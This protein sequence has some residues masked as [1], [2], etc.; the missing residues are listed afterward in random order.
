LSNLTCLIYDIKKFAIHDG[1]GI[2]TT[3][4]FK[5]CPLSCHW[6][7]NPE[8]ILGKQSLIFNSDRCIGC[9]ECC[10][11][12]SN[13][14]LKQT[15]EGIEINRD[16]CDLCGACTE[17]CPAQAMELQGRR[18]SV[19]DLAALIKKDLIFYDSSQGGVTFS[20]GE[21]LAQ[22]EALVAL[23][24]ELKAEE[25]HTIVDTCGF[26]S[27]KILDTVAK[28]TNMFLY[29]L[30]V[31]DPEKHKYYTG[32]SNLG[33][34]SNLEKLSALGRDI[35]IRIPLIPG[36]N[37]SEKDLE[38]FGVFL[39]RLPTVSQVEILPYH[40]FH[41]SKYEKLNLDYRMKGI[42]VPSCAEVNDA[43]RI[44]QGYGLTVTAH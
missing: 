26:S 44:L 8:S 43:I 34:L 35:I 37:N 7:H 29:D 39:S 30:K 16:K 11:I 3:V 25:L 36:I 14:A 1:P 41:I 42:L 4:F 24:D 33:I 10:E 6:C 19:S 15:L 17:V 12:C 32:V 9:L 20:G 13:K 38:M 23:L 2:R 27:W 40:N 18:I 31:I 28:K 21:P 5:G 22:W